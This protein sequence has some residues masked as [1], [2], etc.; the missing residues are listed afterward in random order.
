MGS[1][2]PVWESN[3]PCLIARVLFAVT[4]SQMVL[5]HGFVKK[6]QQT[7][8]SELELALKR[9]KEWTHEQNQ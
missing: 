9:L 5:L 2:K 3:C 6:T 4:H 7:P 8:L 1:A